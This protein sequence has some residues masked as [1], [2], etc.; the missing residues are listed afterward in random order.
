MLNIGP[1]P[2]GDIDPIA[3]DRLKEIGEWMK[4]N[5]EAIYGTKPVKPYQETK[6]AFTKK[7]NVVYAI[8][9]PDENEKTFHPKC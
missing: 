3:Y 7:E 8:Y 4:I 2:D 6:I 9:L 1:G 5:S